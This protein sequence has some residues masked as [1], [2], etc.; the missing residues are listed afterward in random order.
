MLLQA[1]RLLIPL[2]LKASIVSLIAL[3]HVCDLG[4]NEYEEDY[5][6]DSSSVDDSTTS[7]GFTFSAEEEKL[8]SR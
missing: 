6:N 7:E 4:T 5:L 2:W 3:I 1:A 8:Y